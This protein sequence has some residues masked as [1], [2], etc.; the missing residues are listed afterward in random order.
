MANLIDVA[1]ELEYVPK[2]QLASFVNDPNSR[3]PSYMVLSEIQRR[4]QLEK[5][6]NAQ[7]TEMQPNTTVAD[8]VVANFT[9]QGLASAMPPTGMN[10]QEAGMQGMQMMA[11]GGITGYQE[12]GISENNSGFGNTIY[13]MGSDLGNWAS[14]NPVEAA[15]YGLMLVP[16]IGWAGSAALRIGGLGLKAAKAANLGSKLKSGLNP[17]NY[18]TKPFKPKVKQVGTWSDGSP[19]F[20]QIAAGGRKYSPARTAGTGLGLMGINTATDY[21]SGPAEAEQNIKDKINNNDGNNTDGSNG[22]ADGNLPRSNEAS[23]DPLDMARMGFALMGARDTSELASGLGGI[24]EDIQSRRRA[25]PLIDAQLDEIKSK[26][27]YYNSQGEYNKADQIAKLAG[28]LATQ[29][30]AMMLTGDL[31]GASKAAIRLGQ[32]NNELSIELGI[33]TPSESDIVNRNL[34]K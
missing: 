19:A 28:T 16:G 2:D 5:A 17:L 30:E 20:K 18:F 11:E 26:V 1:N 25:Q 34:A 9:G 32:I 4:T 14:E 23:F 24:T 3:Y 29:I 13:K 31:Q 27:N 15:S 22:L 6:Y 21:L 12:G 8:E 10:P 33:E 7:Q